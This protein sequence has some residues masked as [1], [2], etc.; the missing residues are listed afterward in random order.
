[1]ALTDCPA[2]GKKI[3]DKS[4]VC[5]HC[6]FSVGDASAEDILRKQNLQR[7]KKKQSIQNQ[8]LMAVLLFVIGFGLLYWGRPVPGDTQ[9]NIAILTAVI[10]F[11]WY[12]VNRVRLVIIKRFSS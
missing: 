7:Y 11:M 2:C 1:M 9:F 12:V 4:S 8:S 10:G 3:S 5:P 6:D